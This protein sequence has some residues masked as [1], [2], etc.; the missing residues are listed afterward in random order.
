MRCLL[1]CVVAGVA[2][3]SYDA[4][5]AQ[6]FAL[7]S[8]AAY[9]P[10]ASV[11]NW[12]CLPCQQLGAVKQLVYVTNR[13]ADTAG[14]VAQLNDAAGTIVVSFKGTQPD[15][16]RN[17]LLDLEMGLTSIYPGCSQCLVHSGFYS[18]YSDMSTR[19]IDAIDTFSAPYRSHSSRSTW[20]RR[21]RDGGLSSSSKL[22]T[23]AAQAPGA[24]EEDGRPP[25]MV[26]GHS[27]G[28][29]L[30][31]LA[32]YELTLAG[33]P[34]EL[35]VTFGTPRVGNSVFAASYDAVVTQGNLTLGGVTLETAYRFAAAGAAGGS[36]D[37]D[38]SSPPPE[39]RHLTS[40][41]T[42]LAPQQ[43]ATAAPVEGVARPSA[44]LRRAIANAGCGLVR[45]AHGAAGVNCSRP[46]RLTHSRAR[47]VQQQ[48]ADGSSSG[49]EGGWWPWVKRRAAAGGLNGL[50][51]RKAAH[52][53]S[54]SPVPFSSS[55]S[56]RIVH[57]SDVIPHLPWR[58]LG[59]RHPP[60]EVWYRSCAKWSPAVDP[61]LM[62]TQGGAGQ[63]RNISALSDAAERMD[64]AWKPMEPPVF[65][66]AAVQDDS[67]GASDEYPQFYRV[68]SVELGEDQRCSESL[69]MP[70]SL[71]DHRLYMGVAISTMCDGAKA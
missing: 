5:A 53:P 54:P 28:G 40:P 50:T 4:S 16:Y 43:V 19:V 69:W 15:D 10:P 25:I 18:A 36:A 34:V 31:M 71:A 38:V 29:A 2:V 21:R 63:C 41:F 22:T 12:T 23:A 7:W 52:S 60:R 39:L 35:V 20:V 3:A 30:A 68:C 55:G 1:A 14:F 24:G 45:D 13:T 47:I 64:P 42:V 33:Y 37:A 11:Q 8:A 27:L 46:M 9:C 70:V 59:Y 56:W 58:I 65:S 6:R 67:L 32:A 57:E 61:R 51:R 49:S 48:Q 44:I 26:T 17:L 62:T 66:V